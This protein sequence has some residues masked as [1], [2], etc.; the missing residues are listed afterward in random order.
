MD[1]GVNFKITKCRMLGFRFIGSVG[2]YITGVSG[3][4]HGGG[5]CVCVV[6]SCLSQNILGCP[7]SH[8]FSFSPKEHGLFKI[9]TAV[10]YI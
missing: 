7:T 6:T 3:G 10:E 2:S 8:C 9:S 5:V 4:S 1:F